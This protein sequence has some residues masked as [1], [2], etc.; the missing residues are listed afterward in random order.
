MQGKYTSTKT[1]YA[2]AAPG[3]NMERI[4]EKRVLSTSSSRDIPSGDSCT[5]PVPNG[6]RS[7]PPSPAKD[8]G[9]E[10]KAAPSPPHRSKGSSSPASFWE[11]SALS[12]PT[13]A[14]LANN[15]VNSPTVAGQLSFSIPIGS[16]TGV[17]ARPIPARTERSVSSLPKVPSVPKEFITAS[18]VTTTVIVIPARFTNTRSRVQ[19]SRRIAPMRGAW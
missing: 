18:I 9:I 3:L 10:A 19:D 11:Y 7:V 5:S 13:I 8:S 2:K 17:T 16:K 15:P 6:S 1:R 4:R 12:V 14:S